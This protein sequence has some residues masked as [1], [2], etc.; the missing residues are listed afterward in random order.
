[1]KTLYLFYKFYYFIF[2]R[3]FRKILD[4]STRLNAVTPE[5]VN[6]N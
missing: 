3:G 5:F 1:M 2:L 6:V 4:T